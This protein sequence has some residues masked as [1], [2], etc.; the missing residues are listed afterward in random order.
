MYKR[1]LLRDDK[2]IMLFW[3]NLVTKSDVADILEIDVKTL[4]WI[5]GIKKVNNFY[6]SFLLPKKN[7]ESR[8]INAPKGTL[9]ILQEKLLSIFELVYDSESFTNVH[10]FV[11]TRDIFSNA[12]I[13]VGKKYILNIDLKDFFPSIYYKRIFGLLTKRYNI[14]PTAAK[15]ISNLVIY[16]GTL[17]QGAPTSPILSNMI[18]VG[19]D[20]RLSKYA[21]KNGLEYTRYADDITFSAN[22]KFCFSKVYNNGLTNSILEIIE[23]ENFKVNPNKIFAQYSS[24]HQEVTGLVVN[25]KINVRKKFLRNKIR[26]ELHNQEMELKRLIQ[27]NNDAKGFENFKELRKKDGMEKKLKGYINFLGQVKGKNN[28]VFRKYALK[29]NELYRKELF[30]IDSFKFTQEY[31]KRRTLLVNPQIPDS[32]LTKG[33]ISD[34]ANGTAFYLKVENNYYLITA[35]HVIEDSYKEFKKV[36]FENFSSDVFFNIPSFCLSNN[37]EKDF[38]IYKINKPKF[39]FNYNSDSDYYDV[40]KIVY[41]IGYPEYDYAENNKE[42]FFKKTEIERKNIKNTDSAYGY[43]V[44]DNIEHGM[45]GGPVTNDKGEVIGYIHG[46]MSMVDKDTY[47]RPSLFFPISYIIEYIKNENK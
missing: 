5:I 38:S 19:L 25:E 6:Q 22:K 18:C 35:Y 2:E 16:K 34:V 42:I 1:K 28:F 10:G 29:F 7:G 21:K 31:V 15:T 45:S 26:A 41:I 3:D 11:K 39:Y 4:N 14:G 40:N 8:E 43:K 32:S 20:K 30:V 27:E 12:K 24:S 33:Y 37:Q 44:K 47:N 13:H 9:K 46:G 23:S 17:P 36:K